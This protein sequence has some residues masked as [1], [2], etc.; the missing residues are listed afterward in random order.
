MDT[1]ESP[2]LGEIEANLSE[3]TG[4]AIFAVRSVAEGGRFKGKES[5]RFA[6]VRELSELRPGYC[7]I[8]LRTLE[9]N[10][11]LASGKLGKEIIVSWHDTV[12]T[13]RRADLSAIRARAASYNGLVKIVTTAKN[14]TDNLAILSLYDEPGPPPIA[15]CMGTSGLFSRVM[16]MYYGSPI[17]YASLPGE[18]TATGQ[19]PLSKV[20][21]IR[22]RLLDD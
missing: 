13:P 19:L 1:V 11:E 15:F 17:T 7:D 14:A 6:L 4:R 3:F 18:P 22:R 21:A 9:A 5:E 10:P 8:E 12:S 20:I 16:S 2:T